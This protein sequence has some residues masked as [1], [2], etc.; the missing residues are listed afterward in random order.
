MVAAQAIAWKAQRGPQTALLNCPA[1]DILFGGSRG[2]GKTD[3]VLGLWATHAALYGK[4]AAGILFRRTYPELEEVEARSHVIYGPIGATWHAASRIWEMPNGAKLKLRY[5]DRDEDAS[6]Y[7]GHNYSLQIYDE[8]GNWPTSV[9]LDLLYGSL[10]SAAGIP[11]QRVLTANPGGPGHFWVKARYVDPAP[12]LQV[13]KDPLTKAS[14]VFIPSLFRDNAI[15][16]Q[17]DPDYLDRLNGTG[18]GWLVKAWRDGDW[19]G[20]PVGG[21]FRPEWLRTYQTAPMERITTRY[22]AVDLAGQT[23]DSA[24][25]SA[26][27]PFGLDD[28]GDLYFLPGAVIARQTTL[29]SCRDMLRLADEY[30]VSEIL[31]EAGQYQIGIAPFLEEMQTAR[32]KQGAPAYRVVPMPTKTANGGGKRDRARSLQAKMEL[33]KVLWPEGELFR[34]TIQPHFLA[35]TGAKGSRESDDEID[36]AAH[37]CLHLDEMFLGKVPKVHVTPMAAIEADRKAEILRRAQRPDVVKRRAERAAVHDLFHK[38]RR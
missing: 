8:A 21:Y 23:T 25:C 38:P 14:R 16:A 30:R 15:L 18:P 7:Q 10:R 22:L 31:I 19:T 35:F 34:L 17:N 28:Q 36:A 6:K 24:D 33:G 26:L 11:C 20:P 2:G 27:L 3:G 32:M 13:H 4:E 9:P 12:P 29:A 5:L 1:T 37:A